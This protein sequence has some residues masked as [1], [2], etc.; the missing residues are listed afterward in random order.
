MAE[1]RMFAKTIV[2]SDAFLSQSAKA[3]CLYFQLNMR[4]DDDGLLNNALT[5]CKALGF[6]K[7]AL[8]ELIKNR[9]LLDLGDGVTAIKHWLI[10]NRIQNDRHKPTVYQEKYQM[11][12]IKDDRGYTLDTNWTQNGHNLDTQYR[13][14]KERIVK[15][16]E[17]HQKEN[18]NKRKQIQTNINIYNQ[19]LLEAGI[20]QKVID[21]AMYYFDDLKQKS[22]EM[23]LKI[24]DIVQDDSIVN[25]YAYIKEVARNEQNAKA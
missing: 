11:L 13:L 5:I 10:N 12:T 2:E 25:K 4:A 21:T 22:D 19:R 1:R 24:L 20:S 8:E 17:N 16:S 14:G 23:Y 18:T 3:Q 7:S 9:F 15:E 6:G